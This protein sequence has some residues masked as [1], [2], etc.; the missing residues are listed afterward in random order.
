MD[1]KES[2]NNVK[3]TAL[4]GRW[5]KLWLKL[6]SDFQK[7]TSQR[8]ERRNIIVLACQVPDQFPDLEEVDIQ[9]ILDSCA[10]E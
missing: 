1:I 9:K 4:N 6:V 2:G 3:Y 7:F 10:A 8:N 5:K